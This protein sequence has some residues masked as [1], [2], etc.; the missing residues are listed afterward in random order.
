MKEIRCPFCFGEDISFIDDVKIRGTSRT[1]QLMEC[2]K[3]EKFYWDDNGKEV[4][5]LNN[6]CETWMFMPHKCNEKIRYPQSSGCSSYP[7]YHELDKICSECP[8]RQFLLKDEIYG[9]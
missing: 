7:V 8:Q 9:F 2:N 3:C 4:N 5:G 1:R 6:L